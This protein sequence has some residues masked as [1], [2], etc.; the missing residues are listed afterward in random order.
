MSATT[1]PEEHFHLPTDAAGR[2]ALAAEHV[3]GALDAETAARVAAAFDG[4]AAW[5][6]A[7]ETWEARLAPLTAL[8]RPEPP[9]PDMWDRI[10]ARITPHR[11]YVR[12]RPRTG[13]LWKMWAV[14]ATLAA[15][16]IAAFAFLPI[17]GLRAPP[18]LHLIGPV[19]PVSVR[20]APSWIVD[21][22][23]AGELRLTPFRSLNNVRAIPPAGRALQFWGYVPG[24][25][26]PTDLGVLPQDPKEVT[27][28]THVLQPV[29]DMVVEISLEPE[30]GS[31]I[32]RPT[33]QVIFVGRLFGVTLP[34]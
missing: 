28:P 32:G 26:A 12:R 9:P 31:K 8:V 24:S 4:D 33:G 1:A 14:L 34:N 2:D 5:R 23:A 15:A 20:T 18:P 16:G 19:V 30:G 3:L 10:E 22:N 25:T 7:I 13:W 11:V 21:V 29:P 17:S 27:V 6:T